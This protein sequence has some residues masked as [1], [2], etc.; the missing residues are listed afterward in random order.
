MSATPIEIIELIIKYSPT[1]A[2]YNKCFIDKVWYKL[3]RIELYSRWKQCATEYW[4]QYQEYDNLNKAWSEALDPDEM[5]QLYD[6]SAQAY[7]RL[8][9]KVQEQIG[10]EEYMLNYGMITDEQE[11]KTVEYDVEIGKYINDPWG[12]EWSWEQEV[13]PGFYT[14]E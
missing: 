4:E 2:L 10:I 3:V 7:V 1:R 12:L 14:W 5:E 8:H 6:D 13:M 9:E 11:R